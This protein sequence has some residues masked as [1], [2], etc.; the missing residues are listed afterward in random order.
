MF[1]D[2][3]L[4]ENAHAQKSALRGAGQCALART[5]VAKWRIS[6]A[7]VL[8]GSRLRLLDFFC[9]NGPHDSAGPG[10]VRAWSCRSSR[11]GHAW[12]AVASDL[13]EVWCVSAYTSCLRARRPSDP[14]PNSDS[15]PPFGR[16][17]GQ[18]SFMHDTLREG[19][20]IHTIRRGH[21]LL[22]QEFAEKLWKK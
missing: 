4:T 5:A 15:W 1:A 17:T 7:C 19:G 2:T 3:A 18:E 21:L 13:N 8:P 12:K 22:V 6:F 20:Q 14:Q 9:F 11:R 10:R 16:V